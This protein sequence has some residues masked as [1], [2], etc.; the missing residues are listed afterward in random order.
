[1]EKIKSS[2]ELAME[3]TAALGDPAKSAGFTGEQYIKAAQTLAGSY[4][5]GSNSLDRIMEIIDRYPGSFQK[6]AIEAFLQKVTAAM[7]PENC[8]R[9]AE[10]W[11]KM[12]PGGQKRDTAEAVKE[13]AGRHHDMLAAARVE[14]ET[15]RDAMLE[16]LRR[17]GIGGSAVAGVNLERSAYW[18]RKSDEI[19][20]RFVTELRDLKEMLLIEY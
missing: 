4:M 15:D 10:A 13:L 3:K 5:A 8:G 17:A 7:A 2:K 19:A 11:L 16:D 6:Q 1:M 18:K 20:G 9:A 12:A 14:L